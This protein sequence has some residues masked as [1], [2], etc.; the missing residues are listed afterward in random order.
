MYG[1]FKKIIFLLNPEDAHAIAEKVLGYVSN[2]D[3]LC[4]FLKKRFFYTSDFL[5]QEIL[6]LKFQ[7]PVGFAAGYDKNAT[8]ARA[9]NALGFGFGE[10][11][12]V[13]PL[14]QEGNPKPRLFRFAKEESLQNAM[15]FNNDGMKKVKE[16]LKK[17][18]PFEFPIGVNIGKNKKTSLE[19]AI[20][21]YEKLV[22]EFESIASFLVINISSP[23]TPSLRD[24]QNETFIKEVFSLA[25]ELTK[26]PVFLKISPD[27]SEKNAVFLSQTAIEAGAKGIIATNTSTDYSL[28][29]G[30]KN[31]GGISGKVLREKSFSI[32]K[33]ISKEIF[34]H[35]TLISAGGIDNGFEAYKRIKWG[36]SLIEV[37]SGFIFKG[38]SLAKS[39][40]IEIE[41]LLKRDGFKNIKEAVGVEIK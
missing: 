6:G 38:P 39:I 35:A 19:D 24:L 8:M 30:A 12:T 40:S 21:D 7:N 9:L 13:T 34:P 23:N 32:F 29:K 20:K 3:Y 4:D 22:K 33:A 41:R 5:K 11:G 26:K 2:S 36:A 15:G 25:K 28:L 27:I 1:R 10:I 16:R 18:F 31:F 37:F 17:F 14:A